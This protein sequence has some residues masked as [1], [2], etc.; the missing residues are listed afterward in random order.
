MK[1]IPSVLLA[2]VLLFSLLIACNTRPGAVR[3]TKARPEKR[4]LL[5]TKTAPG[6]YRHQSIEAGIA[7]V[8]QLGQENG[9]LV[10]ATEDSAFFTDDNLSHYSA[11]IFL[12]SNQD[13]LNAEQELAF[14]RYIRAGGGFVGI[15]IASG[16]ER[17]WP[18][19]GRMIGGVFVW[20]PPLQPGVIN[21]VNATH[22]ATKGLPARW[23][24][25]DEWYLFRDLNPDVQVL[26]TLDSATFSSER[27][28]DNYP[29][30]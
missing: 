26:A 8:Q 12:S 4:V 2:F 14:Q 18:W 5:F 3:K 24:R 23:Q 13:V 19:F 16:T 17:D 25:T 22:P 28:P 11:L 27:H 29:F 10:D 9:F 1:T 6:S 7:A 15:H 21:I 20:H 30:A